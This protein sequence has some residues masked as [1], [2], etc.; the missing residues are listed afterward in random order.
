MGYG[1][2]RLRWGGVIYSLLIES[3]MT[4]GDIADADKVGEQ[5]TALEVFVIRLFERQKITGSNDNASLYC[6][7][8]S[9]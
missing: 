3:R 2:G 9:P 4:A 8:G 7:R 5:S 6:D 1:D